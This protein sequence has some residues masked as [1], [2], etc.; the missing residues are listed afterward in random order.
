VCPWNSAPAKSDDGAWAPRAIFDRPSLTDLW[1]R[2]DAELR[3]AIKGSA[4]KRAGVKRLR[5]NLAVALGNSGD[6]KARDAL[7]QAMS[8]A[9]TDEIPSVRDPVVAE[10]VDWAQR[11]LALA[12]QG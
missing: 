6:A 10:H 7:D 11:K 5:R 8:G 2:S 3:V 4:L 12:S 1:T 9:E